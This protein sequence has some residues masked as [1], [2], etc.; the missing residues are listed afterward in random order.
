[1]KRAH[2]NLA[3]SL[4]FILWLPCAS[5]PAICDAQEQTEQNKNMAQALQQEVSTALAARHPLKADLTWSSHYTA[6]PDPSTLTDLSTG[7]PIYTGDTGIRGDKLPL[8]ILFKRAG[9]DQ[10][11]STRGKNDSVKSADLLRYLGDPFIPYFRTGFPLS[12]NGPVYLSGLHY[13]GTETKKGIV[14]RILEADRVIA[15]ASTVTI[16]KPGSQIH[17]PNALFSVTNWRW[18]VGPDHLIHRF[19]WKDPE[20]AGS[21]LNGEQNEV[22][23]N[24]YF[25]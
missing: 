12:A 25:Y 16:P 17:V 13:V 22:T 20:K 9:L 6:Y 4:G 14:Y 8:V 2:F 21:D 23:I 7:K 10:F 3:A 18:Y 15:D 11:V 5:S 24:R 19:T 1:M